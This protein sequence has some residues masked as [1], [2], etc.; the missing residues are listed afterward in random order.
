M[1]PWHPWQRWSNIKHAS[2]H[3]SFQLSFHQS[4][5]KEYH[6]RKRTPQTWRKLEREK[7]LTLSAFWIFT[8]QHKRRRKRWTLR[9]RRDS[10]KQKETKDSTLSWSWLRSD[11]GGDGPGESR[12]SVCEPELRR[13]LLLPPPLRALSPDV[14][15]HIGL[16]V[17]NV[18]DLDIAVDCKQQRVFSSKSITLWKSLKGALFPASLV[19]PF[20]MIDWL[21]DDRLNSAILR[22]LEQTHCARMWFYMSD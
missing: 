13:F 11:L 1:L 19:S 14:L 6:G 3:F 2:K 16:W 18:S 10:F 21:I 12:L 20:V 22:S 17:A 8:T 15:S 7:K 4:K 5:Q 9:R